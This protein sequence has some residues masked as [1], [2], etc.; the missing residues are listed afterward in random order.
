MEIVKKKKVFFLLFLVIWKNP[1]FP[2]R[3]ILSV[4]C[5]YNFPGK[6][7]VENFGPRGVYVIFFAR[8]LSC[9]LF[10]SRGNFL[11][12]IICCDS[13]LWLVL[14]YGFCMIVFKVELDKYWSS[15]FGRLCRIMFGLWEILSLLSFCFLVLAGKRNK[16]TSGNFVC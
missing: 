9:I 3:V 4:C 11:E 1:I 12:K 13:V 7:L 5:V 10:V 8:L 16:G 15:C 2:G 14:D 6:G